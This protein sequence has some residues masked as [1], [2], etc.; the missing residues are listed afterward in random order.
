M[1]VTLGLRAG[2]KGDFFGVSQKVT[3]GGFVGLVQQ[4][5]LDEIEKILRRNMEP[6]VT[7]SKSIAPRRTGDLISTIRVITREVSV[8]KVLV[9]I[10][11]G[12]PA[13]SGRVVHYAAYVEFGTNARPYLRPAWD[14]LSEDVNSKVAKEIKEYIQRINREGGWLEE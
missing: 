4:I 3:T 12:G 14:A 1:R 9:A 11:A 13:D 7:L 8:N 5:N 10:T 2:R 6:V